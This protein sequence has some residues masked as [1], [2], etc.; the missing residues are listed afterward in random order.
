[1]QAVPYSPRG[2]LFIRSSLSTLERE[3]QEMR[4]VWWQKDTSFSVL[5]GPNKR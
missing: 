1:M 4:A 2:H 5:I 3:E